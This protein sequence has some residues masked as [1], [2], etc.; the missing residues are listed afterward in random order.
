MMGRSRGTHQLKMAATIKDSNDQVVR[1]A[2]PKPILLSKLEGCSD[3]V[4]M[5]TAIPHEDAIISVSD[6]R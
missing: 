3:V 1:S 6:D 5:A 4:N 2:A